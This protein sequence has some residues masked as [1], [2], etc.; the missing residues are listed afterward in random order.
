MPDDRERMK[1]VFGPT[2]LGDMGRRV[3][4]KLRPSA[5]PASGGRE[6]DRFPPGSQTTTVQKTTTTIYPKG[7][8]LSGN[9]DWNA[10]NGKE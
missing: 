1:Q 4:D 5:L 7:L 2:I 6:Q 9:P 10:Q 3:Q 8:Q